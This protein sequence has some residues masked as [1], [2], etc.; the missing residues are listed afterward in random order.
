VPKPDFV[1]RFVIENNF[2]DREDPLIRLARSIHDGKPEDIR[3]GHALAV[4]GTQSEY[5]QVLRKGFLYIQAASDF[6]EKK[7]NDDELIELLNLDTA[8]H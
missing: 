8:H 6:F 3:L 7:I 1:R 4:A 2:Y 5:A